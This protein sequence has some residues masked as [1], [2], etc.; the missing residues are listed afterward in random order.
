MAGVDGQAGVAG[1]EDRPVVAPRQGQPRRGPVTPHAG[2]DPLQERRFLRLDRMVVVDRRA[3]SVS[4]GQDQLH[5]PGVTPPGGEQRV[6]R[7]RRRRVV[8]PEHDRG[9]P[10]GSF[11][12]PAPQHRRRVEQEEVDVAGGGQGPQH[13]QRTGR[14]AGE[15]EQGQAGREIDDGGVGPEGGA[16]LVEPLRRAGQPD[17]VPQPPPQLRLPDPLGTQR[18]AGAVDVVLRRPGPEHA[19]TVDAVA[20]V[21]IGQVAGAAE[22]AGPA[23][24]VGG[25]RWPGSSPRRPEVAGQRVEPRLAERGVDDLEERP[26]RPGGHPGVGVALHTGGGGHRPPDEGPGIGEVDVGAHPVGPAGGGA[27]PGRQPLREP[28]LHP[29]GWDGHHLGGHRVVERFEYDIAEGG[30]EGVGPFGSVDVQHGN[31]GAASGPAGRLS[32]DAPPV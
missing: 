7:H 18:P 27:E 10:A 21:Q 20:V 5:L 25:R 14:Q 9:P 32:E 22:P 3:L 2:L 29:A 4:G 28:P 15:P 11:L 12:H 24:Q 26:H 19:G 17:P 1:V 16:G 23:A 8:F 13:R 6:G 30:H 31:S